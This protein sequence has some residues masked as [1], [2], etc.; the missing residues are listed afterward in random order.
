VEFNFEK[1]TT[2][3]PRLK[4]RSLKA[5]TAGLTPA[6]PPVAARDLENEA[7]PLTGEKAARAIA[8]APETVET[9]KVVPSA[10]PRTTQVA[11]P[12]TAAPVNG[13]AASRPA[14]SS[15]TAAAASTAPAQKSAATAPAAATGQKVNIALTSP[16]KTTLSSPAASSA[17]PSPHG[18][19]PATLYYTS[20]PRKEASDSMKTTPSASPN[21]TA[22]TSSTSNASASRPASS[23]STAAASTTRPAPTAAATRPANSSFD[24][25]ANVERQSREQKSVGNILAYFVYGL[26]AVFILGAILAGYGAYT[27]NK[28]LHDQS[29][30][31]SSLDDKY[32]EKVN[33]LT[34]ELASTQDQLT[35]SQAQVTR[36]Q[37]LLTKQE[38]EIGQLRA[39]LAASNAASAEAIHAEARIRAQ[40][41]AVLRARI[42]DLEY[43]TST[44]T[45]SRP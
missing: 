16:P 40:E 11:P 9:F 30:S 45:F 25:R 26:V 10:V 28:Q 36:Q 18:T 33:L 35:Q 19:R 23:A 37:E 14:S 34:T 6:K 20:P 3:V 22:T 43:R 31:I 44:Q 12:R 15:S 7:T 41:A 42:R 5:K 24:Y 2:P 13:T 17:K 21:G 32:T 39:A 29:T 1:T 27:I 38:E 8:P 4:R